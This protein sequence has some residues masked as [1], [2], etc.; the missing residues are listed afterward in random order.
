M[1]ETLASV[2]DI[3][4]AIYSMRRI[5][6]YRI[7]KEIVRRGI[8]KRTSAL[9]K[10]RIMAK[11]HDEDIIRLRLDYH[12]HLLRLGMAVVY[13]ERNV[14]CG[15]LPHMIPFLRS[16]VNAIPTGTLLTFYY[17]EHLRPRKLEEVGV[18][19]YTLY[20]R[21]FS[22]ADINRYLVEIVE[23]PAT[24]FSQRR[25][26]EHFARE[27]RKSRDEEE[28]SGLEVEVYG[29]EIEPKIDNKD[30]AIIG[31][32]ELDP[33]TTISLDVKLGVKDDILKKHIEHAEAVIRGTRVRK[34]RSVMD[35]SR[36]AL[37]IVV[38][39]RDK[40]I[41][42]VANATLRYPITVASATSKE[43]RLLTLQL[44]LPGDINV[45]R[46]ATTVLK[47]IV[48]DQGLELVDYFLADLGTLINFTVP[49]IKELEYSPMTRDWLE[50]SVKKSLKYLK[51]E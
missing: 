32:I 30:L 4:D 17:P 21:I 38:S 42:R 19:H 40:Q 23:S 27:L 22:K 33:L 46:N 48:L 39:G 20:E 5:G 43:A 26:E 15:K 14:D 3:Y 2:A 50:K 36:T 9:Q 18:K 28:L 12:I 35:A 34:I 37:L 44:L 11:L 31:S 13:L 29:Q 25:I 16:C 10:L 41:L 7:L 8:R 6:F 47:K 1:K 45:I 49:F 24:L 51:E